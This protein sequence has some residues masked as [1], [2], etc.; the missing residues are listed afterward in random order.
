MLG[1]PM[2]L[3]VKSRTGLWGPSTCVFVCS[4]TSV[5]SDSWRP[6]GLQPAR[7]LCPR[8]SPGENTGEG[9]HGLL[10]GIFPTQGSNSHL[11]RLLHCKRILYN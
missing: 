5:V 7:L 6:Y 11:F 9:C 2:A 10:Q 4:V 3:M 1:L 8:D